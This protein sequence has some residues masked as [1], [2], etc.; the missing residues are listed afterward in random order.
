[1]FVF[2]LLS[3]D[4]RPFCE[5]AMVALPISRTMRIYAML[6]PLPEVPETR[7]KLTSHLLRKYAG[8][9]HD[10]NRLTVLSYLRSLSRGGPHS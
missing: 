5:V 4:H 6:A 10:R 7:E 9:E 3:F 1:L 2:G 8:G